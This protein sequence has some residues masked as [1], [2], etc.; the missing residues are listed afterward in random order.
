LIF[1]GSHPFLVGS[2]IGEWINALEWLQKCGAKLFLPGHGNACG[3]T[4]V[5][6][7]REYLSKFK[8]NLKSLKSRGFSAREIAGNL[9]LLQLP[10]LEKPQR[11]QRNVLYHYDKV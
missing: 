11:I 5:L 6:L 9:D 4:E 7:M 1:Q 8:T 2:N 3:V 10:V